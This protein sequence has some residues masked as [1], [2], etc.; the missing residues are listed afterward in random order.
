MTE[1]GTEDLM[2]CNPLGVVNNS[3][4][5]QRLIVDLRYV[6]QHLR[7][8][9]FKY[10]DIRTAADLFCKGDCFFMFDYKSAYHR[11]EI[12]PQHCQ[13]LGFSLLF[14][15]KLRFFQ[16]TVLPFGLSLGPYLFTK[17][18]RALVKHWRSEGF[19]I[20]TY[21]DDG[22]GAKQVLNKAM[23]MSAT[24]RTDIALSGFIANEEKSQWV[25][26]QLGELLGLVLDLQHRIFQV[27]AKRVEALKQ[28][29]DTIIDNHFTVSARCLSR[30]SGS[31]V[32]MDL[33]LGPVLRLWT[34]SI[35]RGICQA[36][37]WDKPFLVSQDSQSEVLF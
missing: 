25:P 12:L 14:G 15:G 3:A 36:N 17:I 11:I 34:S 29:I 9:K 13:F 20:F 1:V 22:A 6:N 37:Y 27:P 24:V 2:V 26:S 35:Y 18:Q 28:L 23:K 31:L 19:R 4:L 7:S 21:L 8:H 16:F 32:S 30:L 5:K 10:E 33:A